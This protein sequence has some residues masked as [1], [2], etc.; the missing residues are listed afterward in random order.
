MKASLAVAIVA[1]SAAMALP[2]AA[3]QHNRSASRQ[4][5]QAGVHIDGAGSRL[6][7]RFDQ[8]GAVIQVTSLR[9]GSGPPA[10]RYQP[11]NRDRHRQ[12]LERKADRY[13]HR[14]DWRGK[15]VVQRVAYLHSSDG[16]RYTQRR[17]DCR[18]AGE[19]RHRHR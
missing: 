19:S 12:H 5:S 14:R 15:Q 3:E 6:D 17:H 4:L 16:P 13:E 10:Q 11:V 9:P 8:R 7:A 2:A 18:P 1:L